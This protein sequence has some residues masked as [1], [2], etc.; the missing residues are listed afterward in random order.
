MGWGGAD[1]VTLVTLLLSHCHH[2]TCLHISACFPIIWIVVTKIIRN[3]IVSTN[4][5]YSQRKI[6]SG[7][8]RLK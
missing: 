5:K 7:I 4:E 8:A 1:I 2:A 3:E 6:V